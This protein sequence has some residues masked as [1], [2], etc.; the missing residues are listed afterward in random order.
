MSRW[1]CQ[2]QGKLENSQTKSTSDVIKRGDDTLKCVGPYIQQ[3]FF[4]ARMTIPKSRNKNTAVT[5]LKFDT[6]NFM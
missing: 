3:N 1:T 4:Q 6:V 2:N 5:S